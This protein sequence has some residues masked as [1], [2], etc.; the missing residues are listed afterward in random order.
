[1]FKDLVEAGGAGLLIPAILFSVAVYVIRGF[2]GLYGK[3]SEHRRDFLER[4]DYARAHDDLWLEVIIRQLYGTY[5]PAHVIRLALASSHSSKALLDLCALWPRLL[6]DEATQ[7]VQWRYKRDRNPF[8]RRLGRYGP[9]LRYS[10]LCLLGSASAIK[11]YNSGGVAQ[12]IYATLTTVILAVALTGLSFDD[13]AR[14]A[15]ASGEAWISKIND[16]SERHRSPIDRSPATE[17]AFS[18]HPAS[19]PPQ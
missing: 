11:A 6:Y 2:F 4:W 14:I 16:F 15:D 10:L 1:M 12:W 3:K 18:P 19:L 7:T 13:A 9:V 8:L 17:I 5:L